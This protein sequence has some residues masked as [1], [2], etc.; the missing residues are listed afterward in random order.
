M[1]EPQS[2]TRLEALSDGVFAIA[3]TLL[4][5]ELRVPEMHSEHAPDLWRAI[6]HLGPSV[7]AFV[8][9]FG[10]IF[11]T[12]VNHR[13]TLKLV[14]GSSGPF[15]YAN[16]AMLMT[17]A[18]MPFAAALLGRFLA[19]EAA[20]P[21]VVLYNVVLVLQALTWILVTRSALTGRLGASEQATASLRESGR[22]AY[23]AVALYGILAVAAIWIPLPVA[24]VTTASWLVWLT[25]SLKG[26]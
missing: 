25:R 11:I 2:N 18:L 22:H 9:S 3:I 1:T 10:I 17:V 21:A 20:A 15:L 6:G 14:H 13:A 8:L 23:G 7:F 4:A 5:L 24:V 16:G 19:G 26:L 12:W